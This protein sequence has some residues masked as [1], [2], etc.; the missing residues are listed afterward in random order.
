MQDP[1]RGYAFGMDPLA[2]YNPFAN[3]FSSN[4]TTASLDQKPQG[5]PVPSTSAVL[6]TQ[7]KQQPQKQTFESIADFEKRQEDLERKAQELQ[8]REE[9]LQNSVLFNANKKEK[10][11]PPLPSKF[12]VEPCFYQDIS[13]EINV[14]FQPI[15]NMIYWIWIAHACLY[16]INVGGCLGLFIQL[17]QG[18]MFGLSILYCCLFTPA[19]YLVWFR[20]AYKAFRSDSSFNF[21]VFFVFF[22]AQLVATV[23]QAVGLPNLGTC[24][25]IVAL[26]AFGEE[27][28]SGNIAVAIIA[29]I[30]ACG[31][32]LVALGD[33]L[34]LVRVSR[35]YRNSGA[36]FAKAR[37]EFT[38]GVMRNPHVRQATS[39]AI[40][41]AVRVQ[42]D[43]IVN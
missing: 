23:I 35:L 38:S 21:M 31:F 32:A 26:A 2:D 20:P 40:S 22:F 24:G 5:S 3:P 11:W 8:R 7:E 18:T 43:N 28:D 19:S 36:S 15:V 37:S 4:E 27:N 9:E 10:N 17:G 1:S 12:C 6:P 16:V 25:F 42:M 41:S 34:L 33:F 39:D 14:E 13:V 29:L 30:I